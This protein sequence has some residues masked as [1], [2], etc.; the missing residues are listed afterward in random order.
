MKPNLKEDMWQELKRCFQFPEDKEALVRQHAL[1]TMGSSFRQ[2]KF[3]L[4]RDYVKKGKTPFRKWGHLRAV[5]AEFVL[6]KQSPEALKS[7]EVHKQIQ[8]KN[9]HPHRLGTG[10]YDGKI[11]EWRR[12]EAERQRAG[13]PDPLQGLDE[14][15]RNWVYARSTSHSTTGQIS[16]ENPEDEQVFRKNG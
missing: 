9:K 4:N 7:S 12:I 15:C 5:W 2:W 3:E 10:G 1:K 8:A 11:Q 14:R 13:I 6:Q 16:F